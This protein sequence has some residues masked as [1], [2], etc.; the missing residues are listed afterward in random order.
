VGVDVRAFG[1][2]VGFLS[3]RARVTLT[4]DRAE[5]GAPAT[6]IIKMPAVVKESAVLISVNGAVA[7]LLP[8]VVVTAIRLGRSTSQLLMPL[9]FAAH[10]GSML[11]FIG[12]PVNVL[13][14]APCCRCPPPWNRAALLSGGRRSWCGSP[15]TP[16]PTL[17]LPDSSC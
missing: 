8:V 2:G 5:D 7:A 6:V 12:T 4:Y 16:V 1:Q 10:A 15:A 17:S 9:V 13:V 11:T 14:W 3:N